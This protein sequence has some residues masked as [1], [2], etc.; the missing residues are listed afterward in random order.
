MKKKIRLIAMDLDGTL[1]ND[2]KAITRETKEMLMRAADDGVTLCLA[3]ARPA[4]GLYRECD[5]LLMREKGG[6]L[7]SYN[8]GCIVDAASGEV[9]YRASMPFNETKEVL[10]KLKE[11]PVTVILDDGVRFYVE[12]KNGYKVQYEASNNRM[13]LTEVNDL[14][15]D[16]TFSPVKILMSVDPE[17]IDGIKAEIAAFL[18]EDLTV[19]Q[20]APFYLEVIPK[21]INKGAGLRE[22]CRILGIGIENTISFG[23][24]ENDIPMILAAG[25][26]VA[27]GNASDEVKSKAD[28][29]TLSNNEDGIAFA[30]KKFM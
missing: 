3:S 25:T 14:A 8:G 30:L 12:D 27:M 22:I 18:P 10:T 17:I 2:E 1:N 13:E 16:I 15:R 23:D 28:F 7:M 6:M 4:P 19:T 9:L 24:S 5:E 21:T 26:G 20:T 29:V 11:L